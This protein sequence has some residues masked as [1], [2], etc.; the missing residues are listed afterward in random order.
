MYGSTELRRV[1]QVDPH[2]DCTVPFLAVGIPKIC[3][4]FI[5]VLVLVEAQRQLSNV[6][7]NSERYTL[8]TTSQ[9]IE[10]NKVLEFDDLYLG[11]HLVPG[12][13]EG[14]SHAAQVGFHGVNV[15]GS[16]SHNKSMV[17]HVRNPHE[18]RKVEDIAKKMVGK[19]TFIGWPFLQEGLV[20][21]VS[22]LVFKYEK[23]VVVPGTPA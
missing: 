4:S 7:R 14:L 17:V 6:P 9:L 10:E 12:L 19:R 22:D 1:I 13:C 3:A 15:H 11:L 21:A 16:K 5:L 20:T 18:N 8:A 2:S 23:L